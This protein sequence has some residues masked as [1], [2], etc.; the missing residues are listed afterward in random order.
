[1]HNEVYILIGKI[2]IWI[3]K[4]MITYIICPLIVRG[5]IEFIK[6][7]LPLKKSKKKSSAKKQNVTTT[8]NYSQLKTHRQRQ[9]A[10]ST[11][12]ILQIYDI[13]NINE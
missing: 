2:V 12:I 5:V 3:I 1:M 11:F 6:Q 8:K 7:I 9:I 10:L 13:C 4:V